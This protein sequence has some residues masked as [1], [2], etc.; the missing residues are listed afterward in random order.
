MNLSQLISAIQ[1][2]HEQAQ[3]Y[4]HQQ[5]NNSLTIRNWLTG[6]YL[7][8]FEQN[9]E[10][11]A[12]YGAR[13]YRTIAENLKAQGLK[14]F[15]FTALHQYK[16]FYQTYPSFIQTVSEL[17]TDMRSS[18]VQALSEQSQSEENMIWGTVSAIFESMPHHLNENTS[19]LNE[20]DLS[21]PPEILLSRLSFSHFIELINADTPLKRAFYEVQTIKNNWSV[22]E[23]NRAMSTLL[24]ER[25][26][27][28]TNKETVIAKAKDLI[29]ALP[30]D[31]VK[32]PYFLEFLGLEEKPEYSESDL[33]EAI[34]NHL[35]KFL[36]E[37]GRGF[38]FEARQKRITF[39]NKH[40]R[41]DLVFY[42]RIL[43]CHV[44]IDLKVG[45]FD[46]ADAGQMN[47]Y[48]NYY[49]KN[50]MTEH[51]N[52]PVGIILCAGKNDA[53]VEYATTGLPQE[54]FVSKYLVQLPSVDELRKLIQKDIKNNL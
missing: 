36:I 45:E 43:K 20:S 30:V 39:N 22:R 41:I 7:F 33:E 11:R 42:N 29:P 2:T 27:L 26:G 44:L 14:G 52:L 46:H 8:H 31:V 53:L 47:M 37:L 1:S 38:C 16:Q 21:F 17:F 4:A 5:V 23:L 12:E 25:T 34:I 50:E 35:Q 10:D 3:R 54:V 9:G 28:S 49:R 24:F 6:F 51:D 13:L 40:Y 15:S 18:I 48:L 32:N 19:I